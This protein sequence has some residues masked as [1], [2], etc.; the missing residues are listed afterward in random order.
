MEAS[1][2]EKAAHHYQHPRGEAG[3]EIKAEH[4][5]DGKPIPA[6][7][8]TTAATLAQRQESPAT[9]AI[10]RAGRGSG[11][12][13]YGGMGEFGVR[14]SEFAAREAEDEEENDRRLQSGSKQ[15]VGGPNQTFM[16]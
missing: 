7:L 8:D 4:G 6:K 16:Q 1:P 12:A 15:F 2:H 13:R 9:D 10:Q 5:T 3:Q 14:D 11:P